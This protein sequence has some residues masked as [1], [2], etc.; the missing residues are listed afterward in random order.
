MEKTSSAIDMKFFTSGEMWVVEAAIA[1]TIL[2][3]INYTLKNLLKHIR[4]RFLSRAHDWRE[5]LD[6]IFYLPLHIMLW[7]IGVVFVF[8]LLSQRFGFSAASHYL[9]IFRN[10]ALVCCGVWLLLRWKKEVQYALVAKQHQKRIDSSMIQILNRLATISI[11]VIGLLISFQLLGLNT[12]PL[13]A[14]G[15][16]GAAAFAFAG[17]DVIANFFGGFMLYMT[18]PFTVGDLI[19]LPDRKVEG[20]VEEIGWYLTSIRDKEKRPSYLPNAIFSN[21]LV[22]N[23]SRMSH[24]RID[25]RIGVSYED[26]SKIKNIVDEIKGFISSHPLIDTNL[27]VLVFFNDFNQ[28]SLDI[29]IEA[30]TLATRFDAFLAVKQEI[31]LN[32]Q[33]IIS[34]CG[35]RIP[36]PTTTLDMPS[37]PIDLLSALR[38]ERNK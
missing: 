3:L 17:K 10:I 7:V 8:D 13:L 29:Y 31:L 19:L 21:Q 9:N 36:F 34:D 30:Y 11:V 32:I 15:G 28:Y 35:A 2:I 14:F 26:F 20:T 33:R 37:N 23:C 1:M 6:R 25:A 24:R 38:T 22:I 27:P 12:T 16:I 4:R 18:R 5:K